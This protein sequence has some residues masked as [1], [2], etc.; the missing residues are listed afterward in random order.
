MNVALVEDAEDDVDGDQGGEDEQRVVGGRGLEG[1]GGALEARADA[2]GEADPACG[3]LDGGNGVAE[4]DAGG[5]VEGEGDGGELPLVVDGERRG[6][7]PELGD[8][9]ERHLLSV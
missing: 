4:G 7:R 6:R 5:E 8:G 3:A 2:R 1:L 9:A